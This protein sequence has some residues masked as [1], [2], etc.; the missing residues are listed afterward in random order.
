M[1]ILVSYANFKKN[2]IQNW[3]RLDLENRRLNI[4]LWN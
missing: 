3:I 1:Q 2:Q 4:S